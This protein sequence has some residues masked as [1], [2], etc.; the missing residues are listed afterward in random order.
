[1]CLEH[2]GDSRSDS[3][4]DLETGRSLTPETSSGGQPLF[5]IIAVAAAVTLA[6]AYEY[7][8]PLGHGWTYDYGA[9]LETIPVHFA[10]V[11]QHAIGD[12]LAPF[13]AGGIDRLSFFGSADSALILSTWLFAFFS[14]PTANGIHM[15]LQSFVGSVFAGLLC[16]DRLKLGMAISAVAAIT[17]ASFSYPVFGF[18][19]NAALIPFFAWFLTVPHTRSLPALVLVGL[20]ASL[21]TSVSQGFPFIALFIAIWMPTVAHAS[22]WA[23]VKTL[24]AI[25]IGYCVGK[26]PALMAILSSV[27]HS[28]RS[29]ELRYDSLIDT[30]I[31]Y[32]ESDFLYSDRHMWTYT[33]V[34]PAFFAALCI[35]FLI[36]GLSQRWRRDVVTAETDRMAALFDAVLR[37][38]I[39]YV[40]LAS[41]ILVPIRNLLIA[42]FPWLG[43]VNM[44]RTVTASGALL[45]TLVVAYGLAI[46]ELAIGRRAF[47]LGLTGVAVAVVS[48]WTTMRHSSTLP[49]EFAFL[50]LVLA[51]GLML[52]AVWACLQ[53]TKRGTLAQI[54]LGV[55]IVLPTAVLGVFFACLA[56]KVLLAPLRNSAPSGFAHYDIP[57]IPDIERDDRTL[58]RYASVLPLQPANALISGVEPLDGWA[59][60]YSSKFRQFW[61]AILAPLFNSLPEQRRIFGADDR[62]PQDHYIFLGNGAFLPSDPEAGMD[63]DRRFNLNLLSLMNVRYLLSYYPLT[64]KYLVEM[65]APSH[66]LKKMSWDYATGRPARLR[67]SPGTWPSFVQGIMS[68]I[69]APPPFEDHVYAYRNVCALPRAFSVERLQRHGADSDVLKSITSASPVALMHTAH[70]LDKDAPPVREKFASASLRLANYGSGEIHLDA[71]TS[72]EAIIVIA[73]TWIP[74][75]KAY[76]DGREAHLFRVNHVQIGIHLPNSGTFHVRLA[77]EPPYRQLN[78]I[79]AAPT[80]LLPDAR[81]SEPFS[82]E[83]GLGA[84]PSACLSTNAQE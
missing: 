80:R 36:A 1:M 10:L 17:Y 76:M 59:N 14:P 46:V 66:P 48:C 22:I 30:P 64:S 26:L 16:R 44:V 83:F 55:V 23:T 74:G 82:R 5:V 31:L 42:A 4:R 78:N 50:L 71:V 33:Q 60:L 45:N 8:F 77:Y 27:A 75:W 40:I 63:I 52:S 47:A 37:V 38:G 15:F 19:F 24:S 70:V 67:D 73:D 29:G 34:V 69:A 21:L 56:P 3:S 39:V 6:Q 18:L 7:I 12:P 79:L 54:P 57:A 9:G 25:A 65:H 72:G 2:D 61:L 13:V 84:L 62:P 20:G 28:Q 32:T 41:G 58:H 53:A 68:A 49:T 43:S 35:V 51:A 81:R 11:D